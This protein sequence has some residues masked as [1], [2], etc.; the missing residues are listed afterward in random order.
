MPVVQKLNQTAIVSYSHSDPEW[1]PEQVELRHQHVLRLVS[2]LREYGIDADADIFHQNED[3]TR[4]GPGQVSACNFVLIVVSRAWKNAWQGD[5]DHSLNKGVRAEADAVRSLEQQGLE[6]L[7]KRC[8]LIFL[9]GSTDN[10]I[11]VGMHGITR[12]YLEAYEPDDLEELLRDLTHQPKHPKPS[13]GTVPLLPPAMTMRT[14][15]ITE[16]ATTPTT[17][18]SCAPGVDHE[19]YDQQTPTDA[20]SRT[21]PTPS[22]DEPESR[23]RIEQLEQ[24]LAAL[25]N[26]LPGEGRHLLWFRLRQEV[27]STL[28]TELQL[29]AD[30]ATPQGAPASSHMRLQFT[31]GPTT[32]GL[33]VEQIMDVIRKVG[34]E[35]QFFGF[36]RRKGVETNSQSGPGSLGP[37]SPTSSD[38]AF[39]RAGREPDCSVGWQWSSTI[40]NAMNMTLHIGWIIIFQVWDEGDDR[41]VLAKVRATGQRKEPSRF[42]RLVFDCL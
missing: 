16:G 42:V 26:P 4:W 22:P 25:P 33:S 36:L 34:D 21:E 27:E 2:A 31:E 38:D 40:T 1:S 17:V 23:A 32:T 6:A 15:D 29:A 8:R 13:M 20:M 12:H 14:P 10:D 18:H 11:P 37:F 41:R 19:P 30:P 3:W 28:Y 39:S 7:Q 24:Q 9:P 5:G 35:R